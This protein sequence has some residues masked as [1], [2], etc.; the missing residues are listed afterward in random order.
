MVEV[1]VVIVN[2]TNECLS[3]KCTV[4]E[5][6]IVALSV[7]VARHR[8]GTGNIVCHMV[9]GRVETSSSVLDID[10]IGYLHM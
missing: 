8:S 6:S 4:V 3:I 1:V 2:S 10:L 7:F 9:Y 5:T